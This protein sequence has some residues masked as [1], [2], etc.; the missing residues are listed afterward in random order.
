MHPLIFATCVALR[1][2][3]RTRAPKEPAVQRLEPAAHNGVVASSNP[4]G[5]TD[6]LPL[7]SPYATACFAIFA[8]YTIL[9]E[10][11]GADVFLA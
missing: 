11:F 9:I 3:T 4:A 8:K 1:C 5:P 2:N 6:A 10:L 7:I